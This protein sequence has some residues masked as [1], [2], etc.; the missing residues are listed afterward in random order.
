M[1]KIHNI[2]FLF[3]SCFHCAKGCSMNGGIYRDLSPKAETCQI[4]SKCGLN[5]T[6]QC[7][8]LDGR[9]RR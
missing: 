9:K 4:G 3:F 8:K 7:F 1:L 6:L 5:P 2:V